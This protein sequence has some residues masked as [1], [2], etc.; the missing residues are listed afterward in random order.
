[1]NWH[2]TINFIRQNSE[3]SSLVEQAYFD[4]DLESNITRF[5]ESSEF[6]ETVRLIKEI[7]PS[8][9]KILDIGAGN[10]IASINFAL[11]GYTVFA[12]EPDGSDTVGSEAI[13]KLIE[14]YKLNNIKVFQNYA[15]EIDFPD[16]SFDVVYF[17]QTMHHAQ[18]LKKFLKESARV[19]KP[20]GSL[21]AIRD[22]VIFNESDKM[23]F[24]E[25]HPLQKFY[26]G[27]NAFTPDE[28]KEAMRESGLEIEKEFKYYDSILNYFPLSQA[29]VKK[30]S[31]DNK[32]L[33]KHDLI[34]KVSFLG[35]IPFLLNLYRIKNSFNAVR[36]CY[37]NELA[38]PGRMYSYIAK[39][40]K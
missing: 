1:M 26:G 18:N 15:E 23:L 17:R 25:A 8:A 12:V 24:L 21:L 10:G 40:T 27:E 9:Q 31:Q 7:S 28:Y 37:L 22:H 30:S 29:D 19:L 6:I 2:E 34:K 5:G 36:G 33:L 20:N 39:K 32:R 11:L 16:E 14:R 35:N 3:Y 4:A 13:K 38:I